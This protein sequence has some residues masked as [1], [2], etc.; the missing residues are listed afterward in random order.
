MHKVMLWWFVITMTR[1]MKEVWEEHDGETTINGET[2]ISYN[3]PK[4]I[5]TLGK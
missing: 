1:D 2:V 3:S 5:H 4:N